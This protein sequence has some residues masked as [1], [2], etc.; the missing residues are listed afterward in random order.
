MTAA[1]GFILHFPQPPIGDIGDMSHSSA[2]LR[3]RRTAMSSMV[4][5][6]IPSIMHPLLHYQVCGRGPHQTT[7]RSPCRLRLTTHSLSCTRN[8]RGRVDSDA[9]SF[10]F[11]SSLIHLYNRSQRR[12]DSGGSV[13]PPIGLFNQNSM[14]HRHPDS[15]TSVTS[16]APSYANRRRFSWNRHRP[17]LRSVTSREQTLDDLV[18]ETICPTLP[19]NA[20]HHWLPSLP[21]HLQALLVVC[22][23]NKPTRS[24]R[25]GRPTTRSRTVSTS[26]RGLT[27]CSRRLVIG[28]LSA[29]QT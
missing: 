13:G 19:K 6:R 10:Y 21:H 3:F 1:L 17:N 20:F 23:G 7:S 12:P 11:R 18:S 29:R 24:S 22:A 9:S 28:I 25:N 16:V 27:R 2:S 14:Y 26:L 4:D 15:I 8:L 5:L